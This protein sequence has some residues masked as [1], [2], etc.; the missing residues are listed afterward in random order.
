MPT[1]PL[2]SLATSFLALLFLTHKMNRA[3]LKN[4][5]MMELFVRVVFLVVSVSFRVFSLSFLWLYF[6]RK[7]LLIYSIVIVLN[8]AVAYM[9]EVRRNKCL[10]R[11]FSIWANSLIGLW[12][13]CW[14]ITKSSLGSHDDQE[15]MRKVR[16]QTIF[17]NTV[18][19]LSLNICFLLVNQSAFRY[20]NNIFDNPSFNFACLTLTAIG[21][22]LLIS[23]IICHSTKHQG[24]AVAASLLLL[25]S[26]L[27]C[28]TLHV[29][30][31]PPGGRLT[32]RVLHQEETEGI[33]LL[34][35]SSLKTTFLNT[36]REVL[37]GPTIPCANLTRDNV[38]RDNPVSGVLVLDLQEDSCLSLLELD[39][40]SDQKFSGLQGVLVLEAWRHLSSSPF[41]KSLMGHPLSSLHLTRSIPVVSATRLKE[42]ER[43]RFAQSV[44]IT[45][46]LS[47]PL[48]IGCASIPC[49][50]MSGPLLFSSKSKGLVRMVEVERESRLEGSDQFSLK[51][52]AASRTVEEVACREGMQGRN[53]ENLFCSGAM[54]WW[55]EDKL[56]NYRC[57]QGTIG[58][59][60]SRQCSGELKG[61]G[62][63]DWSSWGECEQEVGASRVEGRQRRFKVASSGEEGCLWV[64]R[65]GRTC[66][67]GEAVPRG[68]CSI[69]DIVK[70]IPAC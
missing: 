54:G 37:E 56:N 58:I 7:S 60:S 22:L 24:V 55:K 32:L 30:F 39:F 20:H 38:T 28:H 8:F 69:P 70:E 53:L 68:G 5:D 26:P 9:K 23:S 50:N 10:D 52:V 42:K 6:D 46:D 43:V 2:A 14:F 29:T 61:G 59:F 21:S 64:G 48:T 19:L 16:S 47:S 49:V 1:L 4:G 35:M 36:A 41:P 62:W 65:E 33:T 63:S 27:I 45:S 15:T 57:C 31:I 17:G 34:Q 3:L 51:R 67:E 25:L 18:I 13:P 44:F 40:L 12:V 66:G 11:D